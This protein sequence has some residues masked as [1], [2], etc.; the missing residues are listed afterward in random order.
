MGYVY[1]GESPPR[2]PLFVAQITIA[3]G[4]R[5]PFSQVRKAFPDTHLAEAQ[6]MAYQVRAAHLTRDPGTLEFMGVSGGVVGMMG[7]IAL[8]KEAAM[9]GDALHTAASALGAAISASLTGF[10]IYAAYNKMRREKSEARLHLMH[11]LFQYVAKADYVGTTQD[12]PNIVRDVSSRKDVIPV[13][14]KASDAA[15]RS[16]GIRGG[17]AP[18][19]GDI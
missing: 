8:A 18:S 11:K 12:R 9:S 2:D 4:L 3:N 15:E 13:A 10:S 5:V 1:K 17:E 7:S 19:I 16:K 14:A 6:D